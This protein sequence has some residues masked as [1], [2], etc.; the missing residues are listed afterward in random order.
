[1]MHG[2]SILQ[3]YYAISE[4]ISVWSWTDNKIVECFFVKVRLMLGSQFEYSLYL[5]WIH[6]FKRCIVLY[7]NISSSFDAFIATD[8][9]IFFRGLEKDVKRKSGTIKSISIWPTFFISQGG[10]V[11]GLLFVF[12]FYF[13]PDWCRIKNFKHLRPEFQSETIAERLL[14]R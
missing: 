8:T 3:W 4:L 1:M 6:Y 5:E 12:K 9:W 10:T 2:A 7:R 13:S 14:H 11:M